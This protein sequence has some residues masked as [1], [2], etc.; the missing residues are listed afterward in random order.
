MKPLLR[1]LASVAV[2]ATTGLL[3][4]ADSSRKCEHGTRDVTFDV[5]GN[6]C[7]SNGTFRVLSGEDACEITTQGASALGFP[8]FGDSTRD[9][10]DIPKGEWSLHDPS[11]TVHLGADG[12]VVRPDA[13]SS[14]S[15]QANRHCENELDG[16][17]LV[18]T[19][20]DRRDD[21]SGVEV[22]RCGAKLTPR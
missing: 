17:T 21:L 22:A 18:L 7:G 2:L 13:G 6:T 16:D 10:V 1:N 12:G 9:S 8:E 5:T 20:I 11:L 14:T 15:V 19:C 4:L 3:L